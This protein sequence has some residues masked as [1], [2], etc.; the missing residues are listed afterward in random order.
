MAKQ[1]LPLGGHGNVSISEHDG[2]AHARVRVRDRQGRYAT[3]TRTAATRAEAENRLRTD[4]AALDPSHGAPDARS[5]LRAATAAFL[6]HETRAEHLAE[7]TLTTY[8][9]VAR[10]HVLGPASAL[11]SLRLLECDRPALRDA[12]QVVVNTSGDGTARGVRSLVS[13][14]LQS[15]VDDGIIPVNHARGLRVPKPTVKREHARPHLDKNRALTA[16][17]K[18]LVLAFVDES[19]YA[20]H[21]D[22]VIV[23]RLLAHLG[24]RLGEVLAVTFDDWDPATRQLT[25]RGTKT[26]RSFRV[27]KVSAVLAERIEAARAPGRVRIAGDGSRTGNARD[28]SRVSSRLHVL[29]ELA[30]APWLSSH[31]WRRTA[32]TDLVRAGQSPVDAAAYLGMS[33]Q[34]LLQTYVKAP[35]VASAGELL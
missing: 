8:G 3:W 29:Y 15:A 13:R 32:A 30:G 1:P 2:K 5:T 34:T 28:K 7:G 33:V 19:E 31:G 18:A 12:L 23:V 35:Q 10:A 17:E 26:R 4:L 9:A 24:A 16:E 27:V 14:V 21:Y 11:G 20:E 6:E 22:L 25:I